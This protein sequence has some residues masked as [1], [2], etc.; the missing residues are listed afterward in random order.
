MIPLETSGN[1][2]FRDQEM[3]EGEEAN[4]LKDV[5]TRAPEARHFTPRTGNY[6]PVLSRVSIHNSSRVPGRPSQVSGWWQPKILCRPG[7]ARGDPAQRLA[8]S[9]PGPCASYLG[10]PSAA[11]VADSAGSPWPGPGR[12]GR[13]C[14]TGGQQQGEHWRDW[15]GAQR[16]GPGGGQPRGLA[17]PAG[18]RRGAPRSE[19]GD[20][21]LPPGAGGALQPEG[22][23]R[24]SGRHSNRRGC[25]L[26][27]ADKSIRARGAP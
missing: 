21:G 7:G 11:G 1:G 17:M 4:S 15:H 5:D 14:R 2:D 18:D 26:A 13:R 16:G 27:W 8:R 6:H 10:E 12:G 19:P 20:Q 24:E 3:V 9:P 25:W 22:P 23:A